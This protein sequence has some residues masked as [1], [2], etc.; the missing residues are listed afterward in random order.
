MKN[1][2]L[3]YSLPKSTLA[4]LKIQSARIYVSGENLFTIDNFWPGWDPEIS[5]VN[6][7]AYYP[8][9]KMYTLGLNLK[10]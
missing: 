2:Q 4:G 7:G 5:A 3:G 1:L 8:Q 6:A 10:F 9:V